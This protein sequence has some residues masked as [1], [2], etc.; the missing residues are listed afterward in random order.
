MWRWQS[1][2]THHSL[3]ITHH[4]SLI[5]HYSSFITHHSLL[6]THYSSLITHYSSLI[7]HHSSLITHHSLLIT[8]HF[9]DGIYCYL[10]IDAVAQALRSDCVI[11][12]KCEVDDSALIGAHRIEAERHMRGPDF[13]GGLFGHQPQLLFTASSVIAR[14]KDDA[15]VVPGFT[16]E[17]S[18][19]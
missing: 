6:I 16:V 2:I 11:A 4:S 8:H 14:V 19:A 18:I 5:I 3:L 12:H 1:L 15:V 17:Y 7:T 13:F 10:A 9:L